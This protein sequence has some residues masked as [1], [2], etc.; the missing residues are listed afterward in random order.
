MNY[1]QTVNSIQPCLLDPHFSPTLLDVMTTLSH[2]A[3]FLI[4]MHM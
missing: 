1:H 3:I 4:F 2:L